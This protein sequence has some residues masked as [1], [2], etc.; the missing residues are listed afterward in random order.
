MGGRYS[1]QAHQFGLKLGTSIHTYA[2]QTREE[3][4]ALPIPAGTS[5]FTHKVTGQKRAGLSA[6]I[7][8]RKYVPVVL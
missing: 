4:S 7:V 8:I 6:Q 2:K 3:Q 5:T 1:I